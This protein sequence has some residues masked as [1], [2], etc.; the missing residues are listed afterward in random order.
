MAKKFA[1]DLHRSRQEAG[2][3]EAIPNVQPL[4]HNAMADEPGK[5]NARGERR[6]SLHGQN[7]D[8]PIDQ[9]RSQDTAEENDLVEGAFHVFT[10]G[11]AY[12]GVKEGTTKCQ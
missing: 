8:Q 7:A 4:R 2:Q 9:K 1:G 12:C 11:L 6:A 10:G 5:E 3:R